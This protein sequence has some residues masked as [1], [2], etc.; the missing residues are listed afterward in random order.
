MRSAEEPHPT[1]RC[2]LPC[3]RRAVTKRKE[4][5]G[6]LALPRLLLTRVGWTSGRGR[7]K[8][9]MRWRRVFLGGEEGAIEGGLEVAAHGPWAAER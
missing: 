9:H 3:S 5:R 6:L 8:G 7:Q 2:L 4:R 1:R